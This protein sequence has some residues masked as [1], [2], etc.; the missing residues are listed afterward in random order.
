MVSPVSASHMR[1]YADS[2]EDVMGGQ[3]VDETFIYNPLNVYNL[4]RHAAVGWPMVEARLNDEKERFPAGQ[5]FPKR[6]RKVLKRSKRKH[7][8]GAEDLDGIAIGIVRLH[9]Y[10]KFNLTSFVQEGVLE[11]DDFRSESNGDLTVWDAYKI[12]VQGANSMLLGS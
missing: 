8:P 10:Y 5:K 9:D 2:F 7:I 6:V 12:A 3:E 4:I 11:T 1:N